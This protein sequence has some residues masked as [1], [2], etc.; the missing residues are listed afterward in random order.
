MLASNRGAELKQNK[1]LREKG[2]QT[3]KNRKFIQEHFTKITT[4]R[5]MLSLTKVVLMTLALILVAMVTISHAD[6]YSTCQG[7]VYTPCL[8]R[9]CSV[10][11]TLG[12]DMNMCRQQF[13]TC[14]TRCKFNTRSLPS[15]PAISVDVAQDADTY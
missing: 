3:K 8:L 4:Y 10:G 12:C 5:K 11:S 9:Q 7:N 1:K 14:F 15:N 13:R 6:C 2:K